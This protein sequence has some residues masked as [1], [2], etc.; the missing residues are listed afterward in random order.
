FEKL[1]QL[2]EDCDGNRLAVVLTYEDDKK[3]KSKKY[4]KL[5]DKVQKYGLLHYVQEI[6]ERYLEEMIVS[7]AKKQ[8]TDLPKDV[9]RKIVENIGKDV[10]LL[11]NEVDKYCAASDY[12]RITMEI[13]DRMGVK[14]VEASVFDMIDLI[15]RK[16]PVKAIEKLN[17]LFELRTDEIAILGAMT[18]GFVDMHRCKLAQSQRKDYN[19]VHR[20]FESKANS[21]RYKKAMNNAANFSLSALEEI[22]QLLMKADISMK[23]S[24]RD[25]K[26][27]L[28]VLITQIIGKGTR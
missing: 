20:D 21:Y 1:A 7:H 24:A 19:R 28:Y 10:G 9:A 27:M 15:C 25:K 8:G 4:E 14:T 23:S 2:I 18:T 12:T 16:K 22:L 11:V 13:V 26:Q 6:N 5:F 3:L 17:S